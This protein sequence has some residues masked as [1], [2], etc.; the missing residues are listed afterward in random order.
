MA[1]GEAAARPYLALGAGGQLDG[2]TGADEPGLAG[3]NID[4][5][6]REQIEP[7]VTGVRARGQAGAGRIE[8]L[9]GE[10]HDEAP[11]YRR[12]W[13]TGRLA[14]SNPMASAISIRLACTARTLRAPMPRN[15]FW[16]GRRSSS[17]GSANSKNGG[18]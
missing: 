12:T 9:D 2:E 7:G 6:G 5:G 8:T 4:V 3:G 1:E 18:R 10:P 11:V 13:G 16:T 17:A 14:T 15:C